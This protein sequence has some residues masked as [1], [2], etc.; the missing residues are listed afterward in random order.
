[1]RDHFACASPLSGI[2]EFF[3]EVVD[4]LPGEAL[5]LVIDDV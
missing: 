3:G 2:L 5:S 4:G 1:M